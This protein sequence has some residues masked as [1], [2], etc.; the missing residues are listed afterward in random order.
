MFIASTKDNLTPAEM[1]AT[2]NSVYTALKFTVEIP[3]DNCLPFL[4]TIVTF[5]PHNGR[6][7][8]QN[9]T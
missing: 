4:D 1:L 7:F 2:A 6:F 9:Y 3:E 8:S 5:H